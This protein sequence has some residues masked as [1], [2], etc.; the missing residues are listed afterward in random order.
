MSDFKNGQDPEQVYRCR[1]HRREL[2]TRNL[3]G[4]TQTKPQVVHNLRGPTQADD[5]YHSQLNIL[6]ADRPFSNRTSHLKTEAELQAIV[7]RINTA[8]EAKE[9]K[10]GGTTEPVPDVDSQ[11][12]EIRGSPRTRI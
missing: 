6:N 9:S 11:A 4:V 2:V 10:E 1:P 12:E 8:R 3:I 7:D 5:V